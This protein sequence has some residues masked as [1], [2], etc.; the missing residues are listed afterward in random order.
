MFLHVT[1]DHVMYISVNLFTLI[2]TA[3]PLAFS[4]ISLNCALQYSHEE[5]SDA[6]SQ[7]VLG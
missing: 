2:V 3:V 4:Y 7:Q 5:S 1:F 6:L